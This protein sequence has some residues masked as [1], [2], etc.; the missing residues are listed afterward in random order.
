MVEPLVLGSVAAGKKPATVVL[1]SVA[2]GKKPATVVL[3]S[4]A[5]QQANNAGYAAQLANVASKPAG[6]SSGWM[7]YA[8]VGVVALIIVYFLYNRMRGGK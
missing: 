6:T 1:G 7:T 3:G 8:V 4:V 5:Q 2:A